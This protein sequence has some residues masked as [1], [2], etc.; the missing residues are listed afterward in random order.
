MN[1][2]EDVLEMPVTEPIFNVCGK[3]M[4]CT[5]LTS[6]CSLLLSSL[7]RN[8]YVPLNS[9]RRTRG[10]VGWPR[11]SRCWP[12]CRM[13]PS[14]PLNRKHLGLL[15]QQNASCTCRDLTGSYQW[16]PS[17]T[18][19][20]FLYASYLTSKYQ[21]HANNKRTCKWLQSLAVFQES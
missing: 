7:P 19:V 12:T 11:L 8:H 14:G 5:Y 9:S 6:T 17:Q 13:A 2:Y 4:Y 16:N 1:N 18:S 21:I 15:A 20:C 10:C 3:N